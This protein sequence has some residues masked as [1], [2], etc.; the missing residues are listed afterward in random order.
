MKVIISAIIK[1]TCINMNTEGEILNRISA[2]YLS[3]PDF[4]GLPIEK[5][6]EEFHFKKSELNNI[7]TSL[8]LEDKISLNFQENPHIKQLRDQPKEKQIERLKSSNLTNI[9]AYPS[10]SHLKKIVDPTR[11]Q[12]KPFT[13]KLALGAPQLSFE[14]FDLSVLEFYKNE[15]RYHFFNN[16]IS[17]RITVKSEHD[18]SETMLPRDEIVLES[19]GFSYDSEFNRAVAVFI[20][21][22]SRLSAE[23]Q[24]IWN[25]KI[26]KGDYKLHPTYYK[27]MILGEWLDDVS[28]FTAFV[29]ELHTINEMCRLM[30]RP[31]LFKNDFRDQIPREFCFLVR[32]TLKEFSDF[33]LMLDKVISENIN[34]D[35]FRGDVKFEREEQRKDGSIVI[36]PKGSITI[37]EEWLKLYFRPKDDLAN[38]E[39]HGI[40]K[41][42]RHIRKLRQ[43][44]A[45]TI[46]SNTFDRSYF[47]QQKELMVRAHK[48]VVILRQIFA[49]H[50]MVDENEICEQKSGKI[51][52]D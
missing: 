27:S 7:L 8:I 18:E 42:F 39:I 24:Q 19:F 51:Y 21:Y 37:L 38:N 9:C 44:P 33:V 12:G 14:S 26:V 25:A 41:T 2:F 48:S 36:V 16:G 50:P 15:P 22:L 49:S 47:K 17:G 30:G 29:E 34:L 1:S 20:R 52:I 46:E 35:F 4:N 31:P 5:I 23:H 11:Y 3:S 6:V 13:L 45:H 28:I 43:R 32:P 10:Q 40:F